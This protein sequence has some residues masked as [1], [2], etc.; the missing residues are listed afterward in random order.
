[1][2]DRFDVMAKEIAPCDCGSNDDGHMHACHY[3]MQSKI[4]KALRDVASETREECA[5]AFDAA[6]GGA[7]EG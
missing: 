7:K 3:W 2:T 4:A 6:P 1:M 5:K